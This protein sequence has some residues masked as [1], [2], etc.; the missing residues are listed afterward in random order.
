M[1]NPLN[2]LIA[3]TALVLAA[4][5]AQALI[6]QGATVQGG[7]VVTNYAATGLVSFDIDFASLAP[8]TLRYTVQADDLSMPLELSSMLRNL[9][10]GV[11]FDG[12]T[13]QLSS[14]S[15]A[16]AGSVTRQFGGSTQLA[17]N[18]STAQLT[19]APP[20]YL[21]VEIGNALGSTPGTL[22]WRLA[23]LQAGDSFSLTV[24]PVPEP[25]TWAL[26]LAGVAIMGRLAR[27]R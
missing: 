6:Y 22:N 10:G 2:T 16:Q 12:Y 5:P 13:L 18:G 27:R 7:T 23:G 1:K 11:G 4:A 19:F 9:A 25:G 14:G 21:D 24:S 15:F 26:M 17:L 20:E 8:A 3:A